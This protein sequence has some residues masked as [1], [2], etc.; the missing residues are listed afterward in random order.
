MQNPIT[1]SLEPA[2]RAQQDAARDRDVFAPLF[3]GGSEP[4]ALLDTDEVGRP[5][6]GIYVPAVDLL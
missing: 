6:A 5:L 3:T 2:E 4:T 1:A